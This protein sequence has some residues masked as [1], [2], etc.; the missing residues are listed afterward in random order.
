MS[1]VLLALS[2]V[3]GA[4]T[5]RFSYKK[6]DILG[7]SEF[8]SS[9]RPTAAGDPEYYYADVQAF[10]LIHQAY[11]Y[12]HICSGTYWERFECFIRKHNEE[13][14]GAKLK[15]LYL[16][17]HQHP[18]KHTQGHSCAKMRLENSDPSLS[19]R[20][21]RLAKLASRYWQDAFLASMPAPESYYASPLLRALQT[22][23]Y[24]FGN[25]SLPANKPFRPI[26]K[27]A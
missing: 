23:E 25:H 27:D 20:G 8:F 6:P 9:E 21:E 5:L 26:I 2:A 12:D 11:P 10:G 18:K 15:V 24:M 14:P 4:S 19:D 17:R 3:R 16:A 13:H 22:A 1:S 7:I